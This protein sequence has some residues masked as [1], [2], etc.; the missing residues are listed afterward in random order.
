MLR[1]I[2]VVALGI[3]FWACEQPQPRRSGLGCA[4]APG[5]AGAPAQTLV[6][7]E[8]V[9]QVSPGAK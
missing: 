9:V 4:R 6:M 1:A 3:A 2:M 5:E 8:E 7:P